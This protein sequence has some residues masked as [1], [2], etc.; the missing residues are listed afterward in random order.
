[1]EE[2]DIITERETRLIMAVA[3]DLAAAHMSSLDSEH[4][5]RPPLERLFR[6]E[7]NPSKP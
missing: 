6:K 4:G 7:P 1:M 5:H 2:D 3:D